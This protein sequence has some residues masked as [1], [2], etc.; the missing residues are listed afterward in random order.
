MTRARCADFSVDYDVVITV[1]ASPRGGYRPTRIMYA[2]RLIY[3][4]I[5]RP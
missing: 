4:I 5:I 1:F 2:K 3:N